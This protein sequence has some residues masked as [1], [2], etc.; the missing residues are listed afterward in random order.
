MSASI[1]D[2]IGTRK[3]APAWWQ[4]GPQLHPRRASDTASDK[5]GKIEKRINKAAEKLFKNFPPAEN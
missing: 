3:G 1:G 4:P 5:P 2:A